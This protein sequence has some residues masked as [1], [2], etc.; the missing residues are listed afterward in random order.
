MS[1]SIS[2]VEG[3]ECRVGK[4]SCRLKGPV[5]SVVLHNFLGVEGTADTGKLNA[6][7]I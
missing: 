5:E 6:L 2:E 4:V 1:V 7:N 3:D